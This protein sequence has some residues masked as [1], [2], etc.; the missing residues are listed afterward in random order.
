MIVIQ[1]TKDRVVCLLLTGTPDG[2]VKVFEAGRHP[3]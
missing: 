1:D 3:S 2:S